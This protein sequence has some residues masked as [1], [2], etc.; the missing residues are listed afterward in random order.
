MLYFA[1]GYWRVFESASWNIPAFL[2]LAG[3]MPWTI[4]WLHQSTEIG[5]ALT[6]QLRNVLEVIL[7]PAAFSLNCAIVITALVW[8]IR[9]G[10]AQQGAPA[11]GPASRA[12][13]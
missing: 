11:D 12:R 7:F 6:W 9:R 1:L 4:P 3:S 2:M 8:F 10:Y 5:Q 13:G